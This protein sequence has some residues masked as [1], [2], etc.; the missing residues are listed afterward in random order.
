MELESWRSTA[1]VAVVP[2]DGWRRRSSPTAASCRR[3]RYSCGRA[4]NAVVVDRLD[5][6]GVSP[7]RQTR[8]GEGSRTGWPSA[9]VQPPLSNSVLQIIFLGSRGHRWR[10][11]A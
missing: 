3:S 2:T 9:L 8:Q 4:R 10:I 7:I 5:L 11:G 1:K 6:E